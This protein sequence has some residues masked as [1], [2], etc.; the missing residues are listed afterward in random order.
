M[1]VGRVLLLIPH[2][3]DELVGTAAMIDRHLG[4]GGKVFGLYLTSG[5]PAHAGSWLGGRIRYGRSVA[6]RWQEASEVAHQLGLSIAGRQ[7]IPARNLKS[8]IHSSLRWIREQAHH[9]G[10]DRIWVPAYEGG[11][12]DHDVANFLGARLR[13]DFEIWEFPEYNFLGGQVQSQSFI[14]TNGSESVLILEESERRRKLNLLQRY[15]S[16]QKNLRGVGV[17]HE[18]LRPLANYDYSRRPHEGLLFYERFQWVPYHPRID[19]CRPDQVCEALR[20]AA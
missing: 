7:M 1:S 15:E 12:Q 8:H 5:V 20:G 10:V 6:Q 11:H 16:E 17:D 9:L 3:D 14:E 4:H 19:Y 18:A 13:S 2:P